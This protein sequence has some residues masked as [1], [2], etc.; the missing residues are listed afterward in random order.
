MKEKTEVCLFYLM[1]VIENNHFVKNEAFSLLLAL[2]QS[3]SCLN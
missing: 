2:N 1:A 3:E